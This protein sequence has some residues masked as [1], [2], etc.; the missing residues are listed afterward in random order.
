M[1]RWEIMVVLDAMLCSRKRMQ[2]FSSE[3][4]KNQL[5][6]QQRSTIETLKP[7]PR[8]MSPAG[9][10]KPGNPLTVRDSNVIHG[11]A[12]EKLSERTPFFLHYGGDEVPSPSPTKL[13]LR[14]V[15]IPTNS[16]LAPD[17]I[18]EDRDPESI[19]HLDA[20]VSLHARLASSSISCLA[21]HT[22]LTFL[23]SPEPFPFSTS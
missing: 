23:A 19:H 9:A 22:S 5:P 8:S 21:L 18:R 15:C 20:T 3:V 6:A 14:Q 4:S 16:L 12:E 13:S 2:V 1:T 10:S 7:H 11:R 17:N